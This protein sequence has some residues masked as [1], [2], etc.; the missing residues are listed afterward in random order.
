MDQGTR[1]TLPPGIAEKELS[2][3]VL[4]KRCADC[5]LVHRSTNKSFCTIHN[6]WDSLLRESL[7]DQISSERYVEKALNLPN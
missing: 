7:A 3:I 1:G 2:R 4:D 5:P 6:H